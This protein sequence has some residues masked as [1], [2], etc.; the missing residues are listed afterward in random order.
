MKQIAP[1]KKG[2]I[3][4]IDITG[5]GSSGEGVGKYS[6]PTLAGGLG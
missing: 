1:V 3:I 4:D 2:D 5:L 6:V